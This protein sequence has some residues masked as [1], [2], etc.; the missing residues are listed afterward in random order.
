MGDFLTLT[1][2]LEL[3]QFD[4]LVRLVVSLGIGLVIG[5]EREFSSNNK[6]EIFA[7]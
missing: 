1:D 5:L 7:G 2:K 3:T 4:F 6:N